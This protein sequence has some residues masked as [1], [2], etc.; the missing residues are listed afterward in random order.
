MEL[1][2]LFALLLVCSSLV[3]SA[4]VFEHAV[5]DSLPLD[6]AWEMAYLPYAYETVEVPQF[7][8]VTVERAVPGYWEDMVP[9]FRAAGMT[10]EFRPNPFFRTQE[11]PITGSADDTTVPGIRGSFHYR[12]TVN[13][14]RTGPAVLWFEGVRNSVR[15]WV[16]GRFAGVH[17]GFSTPFE[18]EV[19]EDAL[20]TGANEIVLSVSNDPILGYGDYV[21][22]LTTRAVFRSTGGV[23]GSVELRFLKSD[24]ADAYVTTAKD[25][26]SFTVH[27]SG[28]DRF[29]YEIADGEKVLAKG[30]ASGD[31][32]LLTE[33]FE[34]WSPE[35]PKRY[36]L[37]LMTEKG[38]YRAKFGIR[39]LTAQ[40]EKFLLNGRP[41]YLRGVTEHC[42][43]P[44]TVHLPR[45]I[46]YYRMITA[47]RK[48]L[49]F[50][51]VR[52]HTFIPPVEYLE[53]MDELG[54][55]AHIES[56]N[57]VAVAEYAE[58]VA[59]ARTHPSAVI[60]CTG[61][62]TRIDRMA[63]TY[64]ENVADLVHSGTDALF[65]PMSAMRGV[66]YYLMPG[67]DVIVRNPF[68]HNPERMAR[69]G[70][71]CDMFTSYQLG[72]T[73]Y[74]SLNSKGPETLD[75]WGD[76]YCGK[77]RTSHE[78]CI[79]GSYVDFSLEKMYPPDSPILKAGIFSGLRRQL[80]DRGLID[81]ADTYFRNS[82]EWMRRIRKF[83]FEKLRAADRVAGYDF[84]GDINT[85][86]HTYGYSVG[87]MDEFYRLKPGETVENVLRYNSAAVL[88]CDLGSDFNVTAGE[89]KRI[90]FSVSNYAADAADTQFAIEL[91][92][93]E[94]GTR[95][96]TATRDCGAIANGRLTAL[97]TFDVEVPAGNGPKKYALR[98]RIGE[99]AANEWEIYA[100]P[101]SGEADSSP[102]QGMEVIR[103][104][105]D[106]SEPD[107]QS[108]M[109]RGERVLLLGTGPFKSLPTTYR[110]G[111]AGRCA[112]NFATV[113]KA[114]HPALKGLPHEGFCGWQ[115]RRLMEGGAAVQLEAGV[116]FDPIIEIVSAA[117]CVI[118]QAGLF[119]YRIGK[120]CLL[121]CS[122]NFAESD[123]AARWLKDRLIAYAA[124]DAFAPTQALSADE[125]HAVI[126]APLLSGAADSN[127]ARNPNDPSSAVRADALAL[128]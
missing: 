35:N 53:A 126:A 47:K 27:V 88:L 32:S 36:D 51:F 44:K 108:A 109:K 118:R 78:I 89:K 62:E 93:A 71:F 29:S 67:K 121:V 16:N 38:A 68:P 17:A 91:A 3:A 98:A 114:G 2:R 59:F 1:K 60:Y 26:K 5:Y 70:T 106:I 105:T 9:A 120:G 83:T 4:A 75:A 87:M 116:P 119:E 79:D 103:I 100:F 40:G 82:C 99:V 72:L 94:D 28:K 20:R 15:V 76:L 31:F 48:E 11:F 84:L 97:G 52:F 123:P 8:G 46:G 56:P 96:W 34:F 115:F 107:L 24:L 101:K 61:N 37:R 117:K 90:A 57:F 14:D 85:H 104:V 13:L 112:G 124:S 74:E 30:E 102:L 66:E 7:R 42:Y 19:P 122:F 92:D 81:R 6:G 73:S 65:S 21:S 128:P 125:L 80:T 25:L 12:R 49:G 50:N 33:G 55:V 77:P 54:M 10:D 39:R 45:D 58:I 111:M 18:M 69:L 86:W 43:F 23:N 64:L 110:I 113:I 41:I 63:E 127:R 95:V 22:G